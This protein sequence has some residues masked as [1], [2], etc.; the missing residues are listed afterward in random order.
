MLCVSTKLLIAITLL[1]VAMIAYLVVE[2][3]VKQDNTSSEIIVEEENK[4]NPPEKSTAD[5]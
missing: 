5:I 2:I 3:R 4:L 1:T